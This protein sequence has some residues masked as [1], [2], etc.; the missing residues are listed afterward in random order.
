[1]QDLQ[2]VLRVHAAA[3]CSVS[4]GDISEDRRIAQRSVSG[5]LDT[6]AMRIVA[7]CAVVGDRAVFKLQEPGMDAPAR[8]NPIAD[9]VISF[10][11]AVDD[12]QNVEGW[13]RVERINALS[14]E[15]APA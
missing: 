15:D 2:V 7:A 3:I 1:M 13:R 11:R 4:S 8:A 10:G 14:K 9:E 12:T 5:D 6:A